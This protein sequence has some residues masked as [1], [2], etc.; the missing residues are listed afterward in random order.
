MLSPGCEMASKLLQQATMLLVLLLLISGCQQEEKIT[1]ATTT[2]L[3]DSGLL[4]QLLPQFSSESGIAVAVIAV[5]TG[6]ALE[7]GRKGDVDVVFVHSKEDELSFVAQGFGEERYEVMYNDF[8]IVGPMESNLPAN[9]VSTYDPLGVLEVIREQNLSFLSRGD[10]SGTHRKELKLWELIG[11]TGAPSFSNYREAGVGMGPLL[12]MA[13][14][15]RSFTLT[16][17]ATFLN[18]QDKL[19]LIII[20]ESS[21]M[22]ANYYGIIK[23][24]GKLFP[25]INSDGAAKLIAWL[26]SE[27]G[28][29]AVANYGVSEFGESLFYPA[30]SG[31]IVTYE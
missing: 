7:L 6:Q 23:L 16:D 28:Q 18:L 30:A 24:N 4:D 17:R 14:E 9:D 1:M 27:Q 19:D 8:I 13:S 31:G 29:S 15:T 22:L 10:D 5:G 2:S 11:E 21:E 25:D 20:A 3:A 12:T 26:L